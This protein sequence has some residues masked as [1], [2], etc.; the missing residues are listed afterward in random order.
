M[1]SN[2]N[3]AVRAWAKVGALASLVDLNSMLL[4]VVV[5]L[6]LLVLEVVLDPFSR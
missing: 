3:T 2:N 1:A 6:D 4:T 5:V